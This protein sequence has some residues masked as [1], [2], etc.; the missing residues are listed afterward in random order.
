MIDYL[1]KIMVE[2]G[3]Q[4]YQGTGHTPYV[5]RLIFDI[6]TGHFITR[7]IKYNQGKLSLYI[8]IGSKISKLLGTYNIKN[9][10]KC[11]KMYM[12]EQKIYL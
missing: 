3:T 7:L 10:L 5:G 11:K 9:I 1:L 4:L 6:G 12:H 2:W 8:L